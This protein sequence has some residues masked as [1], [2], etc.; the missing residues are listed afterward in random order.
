MP[1][2]QDW[3]SPIPAGFSGG[4]HAE[5]AYTAGEAAQRLGVSERSIR[6]LL[7][8]DP[9]FPR[10]YIGRLVRIPAKGL[11]AWVEEAAR[12][13]RARTRSA[14]E[15]LKRAGGQRTARMSAKV[16]KWKGPWWVF[17]HHRGTRRTRK[18]GPRETDR[19]RAE[20]IALEVNSALIPGTP[21]TANYCIDGRHVTV[22][23]VEEGTGLDLFP[24]FAETTVRERR[25]APEVGCPD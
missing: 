2:G 10:F 1:L 9:A 7:A 23:E 14:A 20:R 3:S 11:E 21:R 17:V 8:E 4:G 19:R 18:V 6:T 12:K 5:I 24:R 13:E 15:T 16:K 25:L 22:G